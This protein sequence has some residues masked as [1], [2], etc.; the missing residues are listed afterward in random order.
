MRGRVAPPHPD[1]YRVPPRAVFLFL[2]LQRIHWA[3]MK[4]KINVRMQLKHGLSL[5]NAN[6]QGVWSELHNNGV[7]IYKVSLFI[8]RHKDLILIWIGFY[9]SLVN[10]KYR[11]RKI[12][13]V[14][15]PGLLANSIIWSVLGL[16][17]VYEFRAPSL[18]SKTK[19]TQSTPS[20]MKLASK[21]FK[22]LIYDP[23]Q[24]SRLHCLAR[25]QLQLS[26]RKILFFL[27]CLGARTFNKQDKCVNGR[28]LQ[29]ICI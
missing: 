20:L 26:T 4:T 24:S 12:S 23:E 5:H 6:N 14:R 10:S 27:T 29:K 1:L 19:T 13:I 25:L 22:C 3:F 18:S 7:I 9:A 28:L 2:T 11:D 21:Y 15:R 8:N 16:L 17:I